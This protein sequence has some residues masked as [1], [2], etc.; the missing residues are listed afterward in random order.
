MSAT[1]LCPVCTAP[2]EA[3]EDE[4]VVEEAAVV[5]EVVEAVVADVVAAVVSVAIVEASV[6]ASV[7][8]TVASS[9]SVTI[10]VQF[11]STPSVT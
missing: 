9:P 1:L 5:A 11:A 6:V 8:G 3:A 7:E 2:P 10:T 4:P